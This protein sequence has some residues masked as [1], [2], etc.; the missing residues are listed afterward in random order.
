[1]LVMYELGFIPRRTGGSAVNFEP[2]KDSIW[3]GMGA[4]NFHRPHPDSE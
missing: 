2:G 4:I 3:H 1:M